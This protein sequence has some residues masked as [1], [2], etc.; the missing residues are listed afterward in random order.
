MRMDRV[1]YA[2]YY[3]GVTQRQT[4]NE[5]NEMKIIQSS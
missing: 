4:D 2:S 1:S 5:E 3:S